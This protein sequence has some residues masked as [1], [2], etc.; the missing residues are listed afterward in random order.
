[1]ISGRVDATDSH[2]CEKIVSNGSSTAERV[3][4]EA[5]LPSLIDNNEHISRKA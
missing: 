1:M 4:D 2:G 5:E 3:R